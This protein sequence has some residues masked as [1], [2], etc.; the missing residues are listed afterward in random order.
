MN[1][2][3]VLILFVNMELSHYCIDRYKDKTG[4]KRPY[5]VIIKDWFNGDIY[6]NASEE[7]KEKL[8]AEGRQEG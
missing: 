2:T 8:R 6:N 7:V 5:W 4:D 3:T 1:F